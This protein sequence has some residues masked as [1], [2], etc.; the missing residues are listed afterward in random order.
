MAARL[1]KNLDDLANSTRLLSVKRDATKKTLD[2]A[3]LVRIQGKIKAEE[4]RKERANRR[5][6]IFPGRIA[7]TSD[8]DSPAISIS[9]E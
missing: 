9:K 8:V 6:T 7:F 4:K 1:L 3:E 2:F 5:K